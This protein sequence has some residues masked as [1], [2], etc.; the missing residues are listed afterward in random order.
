[1]LGAAVV[2]VV[3]EITVL[4]LILF[5]TRR[6][7]PSIVKASIRAALPPTVVMAAVVWP[8]RDTLLGVPI[9]IAAFALVAVASGALPLA[10]IR[11]SV[12]SNREQD[13]T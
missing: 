2:T 10:D 6:I 1:M 11:R 5:E 3:T 13:R 9:G 7:S 12:T 4:G 8:F